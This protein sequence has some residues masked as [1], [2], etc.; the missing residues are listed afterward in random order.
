MNSAHLFTDSTDNC[1]VH[2]E[3]PLAITEDWNNILDVKNSFNFTVWHGRITD[4]EGKDI[5]GHTKRWAV[6][7]YL[8]GHCPVDDTCLWPVCPGLELKA[9][10]AWREGAQ[11][12]HW[13]CK[14]NVGLVGGSR[15]PPKTQWADTWDL[16]GGEGKVTFGKKNFST[17]D[18]WFILS[19]RLCPS[20]AAECCGVLLWDTCMD[21]GSCVLWSFGVAG[22]TEGHVTLPMAKS[23]W[24]GEGNCF[25]KGTLPPVKNLFWERYYRG[26]VPHWLVM[27]LP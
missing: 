5:L 7:C 22:D 24:G 4:G 25:R 6:T 27:P 18:L 2:T 14:S 9:E 8:S 13:T 21:P 26:S 16:D 23:Q 11:S 10:A 20:R 19:L 15:L 1:H 3:Y 17:R 12:F